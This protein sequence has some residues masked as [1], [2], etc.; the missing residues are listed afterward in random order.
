MGWVICG[1]PPTQALDIFGP[2]ILPSDHLVASSV[3]YDHE[4]RRMI[5][6]ISPLDDLTTISWGLHSHLVLPSHRLAVYLNV[7]TI[8]DRSLL[9]SDSDIADI[10]LSFDTICYAVYGFSTL[11]NERDL[12][13][14]PALVTTLFYGNSHAYLYPWHIQERSVLGCT[15][16]ACQANGGAGGR[17]MFIFPWLVPAQHCI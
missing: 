1:V 14:H 7:Q 11:M 13:S 3:A 2:R 12:R 17:T 9:Q 15:K 8:A 10:A 4:N 6:C 5:F 16:S